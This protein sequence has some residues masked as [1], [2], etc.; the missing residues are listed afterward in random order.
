MAAAAHAPFISAAAPALFGFDSFTELGK[1]RDLAK[2]F[3]S[4]EYTKWRSFRDS[5]DS[6]YVVLV[7]PRTLARLP[8]G[9]ETMPIDE[10]NFEEDVRRRANHAQVPVGER[11]LRAG[12]RITKRLRP[13]RLAAPRSA[14]SKAAAR[15]RACR[16]TPSRRT[17]ATWR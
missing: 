9:A 16:P 12:P 14:A 4:A 1:P 8:Y 6:R 10:F 2:I 3:E 13:V 17:T 5:E 15:S 7:L 11:G